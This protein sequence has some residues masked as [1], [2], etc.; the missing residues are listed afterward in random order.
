M[1]TKHFTHTFMVGFTALAVAGCASVVAEPVASPTTAPTAGPTNQ[2]PAATPETLQEDEGTPVEAWTGTIVDLPPG[3]QFGQL[4]RRDDGEEFGLGTRTDTV[5]EQVNEAR[6][7]GVQV[8]IWGTLHT[9]VPPDEART[10][11]IER[12]GILSVPDDET[13]GQTIEGWTGTVVKPRA[14]NQLGLTFVRDDGDSYG[15]GGS[16]EIL[17]RRINDAA[18][19][20]ARIQIWGRLYTGVPATEARHIE[21]D[22]VEMLSEAAPE[23]RDLTPF[24]EVTTSSYLPADRYGTYGPY[25]AVDG[26][27]E[28]AWVEGISGA[29]TGEWIELTFPGAVEL[30]T[31]ALDVGYDKSADLFAKNNRLKRATVVFSSG[32]QVTIDFDDTRGLQEFAMDRAPGPNPETTSLRIIIEEVYSGTTYDDTCLAEVEVWGITK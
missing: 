14:G 3:N 9:G 25:A 15:I 8:K 30:R 11:E 5:R 1:Y 32:E 13:E 19:S 6:T 16:D 29:G 21:A 18:W 26:S 27:K 2:P 23:A 17:R 7:T 31:L 28:T 24:A 4:F 12:L 22:R 10:I 20:G